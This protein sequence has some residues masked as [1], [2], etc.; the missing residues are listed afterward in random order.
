MPDPSPSCPE[1][2]AALPADASPGECPSCAA[3]RALRDAASEAEVEGSDRVPAHLVMSTEARPELALAEAATRS[4]GAPEPSPDSLIGRVRR[5]PGLTGVEPIGRG[6]MGLVFRARQAELDR[7]VAVKVIAPH[8]ARAAGFRERFTREARTLAALD[9]PHVVRV[10]D[11]GLQEDL[12][13]LVMELVG[14]GTLRDEVARG[15]LALDRALEVLEQV[16]GALSAAHAQGWIHRD[17]KPENVLLTR[18]GEVKVAD[19]GLARLISPSDDERVTTQGVAVGTPRYM[20]P[21]Q[22]E[23]PEA[24]DHRADVYALGLLA[25][26]LL[27]GWLPT[28]DSFPSLS[29]VAGID[30]ALEEVVLRAL[31]RDPARRFSSIDAMLAALRAASGARHPSGGVPVVGIPWRRRVK[32][33]IASR[34]AWVIATGAGFTLAFLLARAEEAIPP[35]PLALARAALDEDAS[36]VEQ[37]RHVAALKDPRLH[38]QLPGLLRDLASEPASAPGVL[39]LAQALGA[40]EA[41]PAELRLATLLRW[42]DEDPSVDAGP[43]SF[44]GLS[45]PLGRARE[46]LAAARALGPGAAPILLRAVV[47]RDLSDDVVAAAVFALAAAADGPLL[48]QITEQVLAAPEAPGARRLLYALALRTG[49][50][51]LDYEPKGLPAEAWA[52]YLRHLPDLLDPTRGQARWAAVA[53]LDRD[54]AEWEAPARRALFADHEATPGR[55]IEV[56]HRP[57]AGGFASFY[58]EGPADLAATL[59]LP[60]PLD[61]A[62]RARLRAALEPEEGHLSRAYAHAVLLCAEEGE[63]PALPLRPLRFHD[64]SS[65][66]LRSSEWRTPERAESRALARA[67]TELDVEWVHAAY[68]LE[69]P[70]SPPERVD[71]RRGRGA[72]LKLELEQSLPAR[73]ATVRVSWGMTGAWR[74]V[75]PPE[76]GG[77][78][79]LSIA[80]ELTRPGEGAGIVLRGDRRAVREHRSGGS[81]SSNMLYV[82]LAPGEARVLHGEAPRS[83]DEASTPG[84]FSLLALPASPGESV[85]RG[86]ERALHAYAEAVRHGAEPWA[87]GELL[88]FAAHVPQPAAR[89]ELRALWE[90]RAR[91][92]LGQRTLSPKVS[93]GDLAG[94]ALVL[95]GDDAPLA[96]AN[97]ARRLSPD[98]RLR[99]YLHAPSAAAQAALAGT[100]VVPT[101]L[102]TLEVTATALAARGEQRSPFAGDVHYALARLRGEQRARLAEQVAPHLVGVA[103]LLAALW[104]PWRRSSRP[105]PLAWGLAGTGLLAHLFTI[106]AG[107]QVWIPAAGGLLLTAGAFLH[108]GRAARVLACALAACGVLHLMTPG[109]LAGPALQLLLCVTVAGMSL[110]VLSRRLPAGLRAWEAC[111]HV[112]AWWCLIVPLGFL[113][114]LQLYLAA[115][116]E[117]PVT[118]SLVS[119]HGTGATLLVGAM[120]GGPLALARAERLRTAEEQG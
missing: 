58:G 26:E 47:D 108:G 39:L 93:F 17:I 4:V 1:C 33:L 63:T 87:L 59:E 54:L 44:D 120:V 113:A 6:G 55:V 77:R 81:R 14:G 75:R 11:F 22:R 25:F 67:T 85:E 119:L 69:T 56:E 20:A 84:Q 90:L 30:E 8:L 45:S 109:S 29:K 88:V 106:E 83:W 91:D 51:L 62:T 53:R 117:S 95:V 31:E 78:W 3:R 71:L 116:R 96:D 18:D 48:L 27:A 100:L 103:L 70:A 24:V 42:P 43:G 115:T 52:I 73:D 61:E 2:S 105:G 97:F 57:S 110:D 10:H 89:D 68:H 72:S 9:H 13:Y 94:A 19:F 21:E 66:S 64:R 38:A 80:G 28:S 35:D 99:L 46:T 98:L 60:W 118:F 40:L 114:L 50:P 65:V 49:V 74:A 102:A 107:G 79:S 111:A 112:A 36:W 37:R 104:L 41:L 12:P 16:G 32:L 92:A 76:P 101:G 23:R 82:P 86:V 15:P 34:L 7:E 5:I